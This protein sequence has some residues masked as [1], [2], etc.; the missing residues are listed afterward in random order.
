M[1]E[2]QSQLD[3]VG[4]LAESFLARYRRG[5]R[6]ALSE[7]TNQHPELA[8]Q[9]RELFP[10]LVVMEE[11]GSV[12][13]R[14]TGP[15]T[16]QI[17][18]SSKVPEQLGDYRILRE[19]GRGGMGVVYEAVQESLG[20]HVALKVL[21]SH[22][23]LPPIHLE[24]FRREAKAAARLHHSNI[25]PVFGVGE[26]GGVHYYAMQF[27]QGQGL[28]EVLKELRRL[29]GHKAVNAGVVS[30]EVTHKHADLSVAEGLL[31][32]RLSAKV[33][34]PAEAHTSSAVAAATKTDPNSSGSASGLTGQP[35]AQ[36]FRGVAEIGVQVA[37]ALEY[38][39]KQGILHRDIKPSNLLLDAR[40]TVWV[41]DFGLAKAEG[42]DELTQ[43]GDIVGTLRY[44]APE[45]FNGWSDPRSDVYG[46]GVTLYELLTLRPAFDDSNRVKVMERVTRE[47]PLRP[48]KLDRQIPRDLETI[49]LKAM[50]KEPADRYATAAALAEDLRRFLADRT[51]QARRSSAFE[52]GWRWCRRNPWVAGLAAA[53]A[54]SLLVG[55]AVAT[56]FAFLADERARDAIDEATRA[57][58]NAERAREQKRTSDHRLYISDLRLAEHAWD[59][60]HIGHMLRLLDRQRPEHTG[61]EDLRGFEWYYWHRLCHI[62]Q[63]FRHT[64]AVYTVAFSPDSKRLASAGWERGVRVWDAAS[65]ETELTLPGH[66]GLVFSVA[67][68]PDGQRLAA[69]GNDG[70][71]RIW[72]LTGAAEPVTLKGYAVYGLAFSPDGLRLASAGLDRIVRIWDLTGAQEPLTLK[73]H[74]DR[75]WGVAFSPDG[76]RLA[77]A[78]LDGT[79]RVW[80]TTSGKELLT[81][82][83]SVGQLHSVAFS[84]DGQR[85]AT[86]GGNGVVRIWDAASG[87]GLHSVKL[88]TGAV[89]SVMFSPDGRRLASAGL[90][91]VVR[92]WDLNV[93]EQPITLK[94]HSGGVY[95]VAFSPDGRHLA[96]A[97]D[98]GTVK[99]WDAAGSQTTP[100]LKGHRGFLRTVGFSPDGRRLASAGQDGTVKLWD[101]SGSQ[102]PR[103]LPGHGVV[104]SLAFGAHG[105]RLASADLDGVVRIWDLT[106]TDETLALMGHAGAVNG[107]A[108]S[109]DGKRVAS[110][111][112][113]QI[114]RV[115]DI[116]GGLPMLTLRGHT[117]QVTDVAFSP[118]GHHLASASY[119]QTVRVWDVASGLETLTLKGHTSSVLSV[120][121]SP[122]GR[123]LA[124]GGKDGIVILWDA[125]N[126][127][128][129]LTLEGHTGQ[130]SAVAF[131]P[132]DDRRVASASADATVKLWDT[133][134]GQETV[135][136]KG[137]TH[138]VS[139]LA[140]SPD[141]WRLASADLGGMVRLWDGRPPDD[142]LVRQR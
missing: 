137:H 65:G 25:V 106:G 72:D 75:V 39:H 80:E 128:R 93:L 114:V 116:A 91:R 92:I 31:S 95:S 133:A 112:M 77:A 134:S 82:K 35:E 20:R 113:D 63:V 36:Y 49:V 141:G 110:A 54:A 15:F 17:V 29:R 119:D 43:S 5:E 47:E 59:Q 56:H 83:G 61:G 138:A 78:G 98:D 19:V 66:S 105:R 45:R 109:P 71:V 34:A 115:W 53:A 3:E 16:G 55:M 68:S 135:N 6:P 126:G 28:D 76:R 33:E 81:L 4:K 8:E 13:D 2:P 79:V 94:G 50:A 74:T 46:L 1:N 57:R 96:S 124:S 87:K 26:H 122:D 69:A 58:K 9:I 40:G 111:G 41:T 127:Q 44:M 107:I 73:G 117:S 21:P 42:A 10:A 84:P 51:I 32:G 100:P 48:R 18:A 130:V 120:A 86:G 37:E 132:K 101:L 64:G 62:G 88:H 99:L 104:S 60:A 14:R 85:L 140:F 89:R 27:I 52:R 90:D 38:A 97:S 121:F 102:E 67:F 142:E 125:A 22:G 7:Y 123:R 108:F 139:G 11:L 136:L 70:V 24:R 118:D 103:I 131:S 12:E 23:L 30:G 129:V